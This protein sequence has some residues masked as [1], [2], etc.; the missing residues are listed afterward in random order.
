V[1]VDEKNILDESVIDMNLSNGWSLTIDKKFLN[2]KERSIR[3]IIIA[4]IPVSR[5]YIPD[6]FNELS[7]QFTNHFTII[8]RDYNDGIAYRIQTL[9]SDSV[10]VLKETASFKFMKDA[11]AYAPVIGF[12]FSSGRHI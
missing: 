8:F 6:E 1:F 10:T 3:K 11:Y 7:I 5:K 2:K 12:F 9:F 4:Q